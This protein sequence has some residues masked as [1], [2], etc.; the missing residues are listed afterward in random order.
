MSDD[1]EKQLKEFGVNTKVL[2]QY[3]M[4]DEDLAAL[5]KE[6]VKRINRQL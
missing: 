1:I 5:L 3:G 2:K 4:S 6:I